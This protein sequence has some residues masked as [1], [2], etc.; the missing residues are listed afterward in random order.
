MRIL[1]RIAIGFA[2]VA[3]SPFLF[4]QKVAVELDEVAD[5][6][7]SEGGFQGSLDVKVKVSGPPTEGAEAARI[8]VKEARDDK[9]NSLLSGNESIP[10]FFPREYNNGSIQVSLRQPARSASS[11]KLKGTVE[12]YVPGRDPASIVKIEKGLSK[13]DTP[14]SAKALKAAKI[15]ITPLSPAGYAAAS[16]ARKID[17]KAIA[18]IRAEGKKKGATDK[19]IDEVIE[20]AKA[21]EGLDSASSPNAVYLSGKKSDFDR[22]YRIDIL[23]PDGQPV[24]IPSRGTSSRGDSTIMTLEPSSPA[25]PDSTLKLAL[26]TDKTKISFPFEL[27]VSL[28]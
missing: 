6:R 28:P 3:I 12:L 25:P 2:C 21:L 1:S 5:N 14:F 7:V 9:N 16:K 17:D 27:T 20:L 24:S 18:E 13:L 4:A 15:V 23:G 10:D 19:E 22:V 26:L 8:I 11:V